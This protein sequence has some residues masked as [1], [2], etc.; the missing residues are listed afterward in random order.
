V[1]TTSTIAEQVADYHRASAGQLPAEVAEAF[2][3]EQHALA[4]AGGPS[5]TAQPGT[6][7]PDGRRGASGTC[8]VISPGAPQ[9]AG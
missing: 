5:G 9:A 3:A 2:A 8:P 6:R 1:T 4:A 7:L